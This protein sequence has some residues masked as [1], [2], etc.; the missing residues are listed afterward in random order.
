MNLFEKAGTT[1]DTNKLVAALDDVT[2]HYLIA[3][4]WS[5][6]DDNGVHLDNTH[7]LECIAP[8]VL[9]QSYIDCQRFRDDNKVVLSTTRQEYIDS[10]MAHHPDAGSAD[11]C[12]G[13]DLW[14]S[15]NGHGAGFFD[16]K[17]TYGNLLQEAARRMG[18]VNLYVGEDNQIHADL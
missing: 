9:N 18:E 16:R 7:D 1:T 5:T 17:L 12:L 10:G 11:A 4:L 3:A 15:R 14:L 13:H 6:T 8:D 2:R